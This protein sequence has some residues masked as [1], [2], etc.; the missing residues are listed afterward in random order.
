MIAA[1]VPVMV[2]TAAGAAWLF[3][4]RGV[5][6][7]QL[8]ALRTA[9]AFGIGLGGVVGLWLA[10]RRQRSAELD[11]LQKYEAHELAVRAM[12][13]NELDARERRL[14]ELYL[15]AVEQ[16]GS[17]KA[18][19]RTG[20]VYALERVAH[21]NPGLRQTVV[22][23]VCAYLRSPYTSPGSLRPRRLGV[24]RPLSAAA[25]A[26]VR[27]SSRAH[28][29]PSV[30][31]VGDD[32]GLQE[33]EVRTAA[34]RLL[35]RH[36]R[37]GLRPTPA[38][39]FWEGINIDLTGATLID[40]ELRDCQVG[41]AEFARAKFVGAA[42]FSGARFTSDAVFSWAQFS[43]G[44]GFFGVQ[45]GKDAWFYETGIAGDVRFEG[46][47]VAGVSWFTRTQFG[48]SANFEK[49]KFGDRAWFGGATF[50][51]GSRFTEAEFARG[52]TFAGAKFVGDA[53]FFAARFGIDAEFERTQ[54]A[55]DVTFGKAKFA[56]HAEFSGAKSKS[57]PDFADAQFSIK[58]RVGVTG[59]PELDWLDLATSS[60]HS[61][62]EA[63]QFT[64][65][66]PPADA[67]F[68]RP[69]PPDWREG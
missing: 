59:F 53:S 60:S 48:G 25:S 52:A 47:K 45:F 18:A 51:S 65:K 32:G 63:V 49:V 62:S 69:D 6:R 57:I 54:F 40:F 55:G 19:V 56:R 44:A 7:D 12:E 34:Q 1:G 8:D 5:T 41:E 58:S 16:L 29:G 68:A 61:E 50:A 27:S 22:D 39:T 31:V 4:G 26:R 42:W 21:D 13:H 14:N 30:A 17:D 64:G 15:K 46:A 33:R 23:V 38:S 9:G 66:T 3:L 35:A 10:V 11:L 28:G 20:G 43:G 67:E 2:L 37:P 24:K 36:L